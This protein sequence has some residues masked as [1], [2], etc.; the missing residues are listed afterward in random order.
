MLSSFRCF[1]LFLRKTCKAARSNPS[2]NS[3]WKEGKAEY[4]G[5]DLLQGLLRFS[6]LVKG[7][8][9][10][11]CPRTQQTAL[12]IIGASY[13]CLSVDI[14]TE[15]TDYQF[16]ACHKLNCFDPHLIYTEMSFFYPMTRRLCHVLFTFV[17]TVSG[18][19][20]ENRSIFERKAQYCIQ[21]LS[22]C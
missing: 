1:S 6:L 15:C 17:F 7:C 16:N 14:S 22:S 9:S 12:M 18:I 5:E 19:A 3:T 10:F 8:C 4:R 20:Y 11:T 21:P 2:E 13:I